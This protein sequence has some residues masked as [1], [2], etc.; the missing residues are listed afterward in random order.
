[1]INYI[2]KKENMVLHAEKNLKIN[3]LKAQLLKYVKKE[4]IIL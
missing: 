1:M 2:I 4:K 3:N